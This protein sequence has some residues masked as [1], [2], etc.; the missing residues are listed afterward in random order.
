MRRAATQPITPDAW[1]GKAPLPVLPRPGELLRADVVTQWG[2]RYRRRN[3]AGRVDVRATQDAA[4]RWLGALK[5]SGNR[6]AVLVARAAD[7]AA[8]IPMGGA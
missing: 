2:V 5:F 4:R 1:V 6:D 3:D 8:W 7:D